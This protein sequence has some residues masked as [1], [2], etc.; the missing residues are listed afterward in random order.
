METFQII[1][2]IV[3]LL[4]PLLFFIGTLGYTFLYPIIPRVRY[5]ILGTKAVGGIFINQEEKERLAQFYTNHFPYY[6]LLNEQEKHKFI[7]RIIIFRKQNQIHIKPTV[8]SPDDEIELMINAA[9]VQITF[10]YGDFYKMNTFN[11]IVIHPNTFFSKLINRQVKG[12]TVSSGVIHYSWKDFVKGYK[13][14]NDN[15]NLGLH[16]LAHAFYVETFT[17]EDIDWEL[18]KTK[19][20]SA[21]NQERTLQ[22]P[23][24][25]SYGQTNLAEFWA[26]TVEV[27]FEDPVKF[28][29]L[30]PSL[31]AATAIILKQDMALRN[32]SK[33]EIT[34]Y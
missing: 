34:G 8:I 28:K 26:V 3:V 1:A 24:F 16:E 6:K 14:A 9:F 18:W 29:E 25:R 10:G 30:Y 32:K 22:Q 7:T 15:I 33:Q 5:F 12:L 17:S 21:I 31:Y 13:V 2:V 27:F 19:A 4:L 23:F 20:L 11:K